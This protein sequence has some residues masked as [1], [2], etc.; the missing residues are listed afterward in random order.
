MQADLVD[1]HHGDVKK[2][3]SLQETIRGLLQVDIRLL[4]SRQVAFHEE[5][6]KDVMKQFIHAL[7][8]E[9]TEHRSVRLKELIDEESEVMSDLVLAMRKDLGVKWSRFRWS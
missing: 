5:Q 3:E 9:D 6:L 4:V 7:A 2:A 1:V 8:V